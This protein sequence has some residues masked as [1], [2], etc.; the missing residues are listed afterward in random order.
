MT[1]TLRFGA[2]LV[3]TFMVTV[4]AS[5]TTI[6]AAP[7]SSLSRAIT[8]CWDSVDGRG[9][10]SLTDYEMKFESV[11][12][13]RPSIENKIWR[14]L[15]KTELGEIEIEATVRD[16]N[17]LICTLVTFPEPPDADLITYSEAADTLKP[18]YGERLELVGYVEIFSDIRYLGVTRCDD[19]E[20]AITSS[21]T[22]MDLVDPEIFA[23]GNDAPIPGNLR[24]DVYRSS[25]RYDELCTGR[26]PK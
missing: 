9:L 23:L 19:G 25:A 13:P 18:W 15:V 3:N 21:G 10:A 26:E 8:A 22:S 6:S 5:T 4:W 11:E 12:R 24:V 2:V 14:G 7:N 17:V 1:R 20:T 16:G